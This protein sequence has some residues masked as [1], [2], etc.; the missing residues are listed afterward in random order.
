MRYL[1]YVYLKKYSCPE[2]IK[3]NFYKP[4]KKR[5]QLDQKMAKTWTQTAQTRISNCQFN[6]ISYQGKRKLKLQEETTTYTPTWLNWKLWEIP[7]D[8]EDVEQL[9]RSYTSEGCVNLFI[10]C[11]QILQ[12][13]RSARS[14]I[15]FTKRIKRL[16]N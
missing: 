2:Y 8:G 7:S 16:Q 9:E 11:S 15:L 1:Q 4:G 13:Q 6:F 5:W 14:L 10:T 3:K 12:A